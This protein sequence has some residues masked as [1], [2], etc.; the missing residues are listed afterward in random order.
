MF[1][2]K[3]FCP[4]FTAG[5]GMVLRCF[6]YSHPEDLMAEIMT[7]GYFN[8]QKGIL[9]PNSF[10]KVVCKDAVFECTV[11]PRTGMDVT[12]RDE[13]FMAQR[14]PLKRKRNQTEKKE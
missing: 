2:E 10:V 5:G 9:K 4:T 13:V 6:I 7:P 3:N 14:I 1:I 11:M 12:M 8:K